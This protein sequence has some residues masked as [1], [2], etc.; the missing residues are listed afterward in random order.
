MTLA[1][2][3]ILGA[4]RIETFLGAGGGMGEVYRARDTR[5]DRVVAVKVL[6]ADKAG[7]Q[8]RHR[9]FLREAKTVAGLNHPNIVQLYDVL[10]EGGRFGL[11]MEYVSG[12]SLRQRIPAKGM[13]TTEA[14]GC[15]LQIAEALVAAHHAGVVHRDL[16]PGNILITENGNVKLLDFGI[17]KLAENLL[18]E[19]D[20]TVTALDGTTQTREGV[21]VGTVAYMS[22]EQA[23]GRSVDTRSDIF[24]FGSVLYEMLTGQRAFHGETTMSTLSAIIREEPKPVTALAEDVPR[25]VENIVS[26]CLRKDLSQ[27]YQ[28]IVDVRNAMEE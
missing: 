17:A 18:G 21:I 22:P 10:E 23:E 12:Q 14:V 9:R 24:S 25:D 19:S 4:Y 20:T 27:R 7:D 6:P 13:G 15:A 1:P 26:R 3:T 16:K 11:V 2:G 8:E 5:I 28:L